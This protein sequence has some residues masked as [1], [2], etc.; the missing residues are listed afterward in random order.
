VAGDHPPWHPD[1]LACPNDP[2]SSPSHGP[3]WAPA[4][5]CAGRGSP[6]AHRQPG[7]LLP[8]E[9]TRSELERRFL[10]LCRRHGLPKPEVNVR[11][12][13]Y[14]VD[15]LW[16]ESKVIVETDGFATHGGRVAFARDRERDGGLRVMGYSVQRFAYRHVV[17]EGAFVASVLRALLG[18]GRNSA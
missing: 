8:R 10:T 14:E 9:P 16:R 12:G 7:R 18:A 5:D 3:C 2:G 6:P 4:S 13:P 15:F 1:D 17:D 11:V